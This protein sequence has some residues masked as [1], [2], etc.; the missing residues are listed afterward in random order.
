L[1]VVLELVLGNFKHLWTS[2]ELGSSFTSCEETLPYPTD[3]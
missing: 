3:T 1:Y 2:T